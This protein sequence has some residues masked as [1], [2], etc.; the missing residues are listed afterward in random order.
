[1]SL[2]SVVYCQVEVFGFGC[3]LV[4]RSPNEGVVSKYNSEASTVRDPGPR[5]TVAPWE[6][7]GWEGRT[8]TY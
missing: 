1:M 7:G 5:W 8:E 2:V 3:S 4:Q 6:W